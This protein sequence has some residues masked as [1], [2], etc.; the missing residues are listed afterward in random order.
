MSTGPGHAH[1]APRAELS[2]GH[3]HG[4]PRAEL[5]PGHA[6]GS[7]RPSVRRPT[8]HRPSGPPLLVG[9][10]LVVLGLLAWLLFASSVLGVREIVVNGAAI[11]SA[12]DIRAATGVVEGTPLLR[13]DTADVAARVAALPPV[14]TVDVRRSLPHTLVI[15]V[16]ERRPAAAVPAGGG[17]D[18]IDASGVVFQ[19]LPS[20]PAGVGVI[21]VA[22]PGPDDA[23][24]LAALRVLAA[25]T[26]Q[27]RALLA[28]V[29]APT[30]TGISLLLVD[31]RTVLWGD[32]EHS[33]TKARVATTMLDHAA[34]SINVTVP[35]IVTVS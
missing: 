17:Y 4:A 33:E 20:R 23:A 16:A 31:G 14:A 30:T 6:H 9:V 8:A 18:L 1:G 7:A 2:P 3:A 26:P 10:G 24:T 25:L 11:A 19:H 21:R 32:A 35:D 22:T 12:D 34:N 27:L 5:S 15:T 28:E 13:L 29:A